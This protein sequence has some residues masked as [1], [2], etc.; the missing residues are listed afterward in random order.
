MTAGA[1]EQPDEVIQRLD[2]LLD[3]FRRRLLDDRDKRAMLQTLA[4]RLELAERRREPEFVRPLAHRLVLVLDRIR[5]SG[6]TDPFVASVAE[7]LSDVLAS[8]G[9]VEVP[10]EGPV[11]PH[12]HEV[13]D[14][15]DAAPSDP[16]R[17]V[18]VL[19]RGYAKD[20]IVIRPAT[21]RAER[22]G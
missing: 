7:E 19:R 2:A 3:L 21:V 8:I 9:V 6:S 1:P 22:A 13:V 5:N 17:I 11:L 4:E 18:E 12:E 20:A 10:A 16:L 14:A 15:G